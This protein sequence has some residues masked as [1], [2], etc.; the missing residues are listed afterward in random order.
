MPGTHDIPFVANSVTK[1]P[2]P[3]EANPGPYDVVLGFV[4]MHPSLLL[5][6]MEQSVELI[7]VL[8]WT[9]LLDSMHP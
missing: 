6:R 8:V 3:E 4:T 9:E 7:K 1:I 5:A 2:P